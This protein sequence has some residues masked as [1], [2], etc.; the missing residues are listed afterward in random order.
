MEPAKSREPPK[1]S[2]PSQATTPRPRSRRAVWDKTLQ[3]TTK[4]AETSKVPEAT[5]LKDHT[6]NAKAK[7]PTSGTRQEQGAPKEELP[8]PGNHPKAEEQNNITEAMPKP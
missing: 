6:V 7:E 8:K 2:C 1:R 5:E 4:S 3:T